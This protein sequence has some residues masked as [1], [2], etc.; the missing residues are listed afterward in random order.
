MRG[1][2]W[3]GLVVQALG[4]GSFE[5]E[6]KKGRGVSKIGDKEFNVRKKDRLDRNQMKIGSKTARR[7]RS[8]GQK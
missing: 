4:M 3:V 6:I 7:R 8:K 1:L 5:R 2:S